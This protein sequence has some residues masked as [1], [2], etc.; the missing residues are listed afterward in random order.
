M[1]SAHRHPA[2]VQSMLWFLSW[3][4]QNCGITH[5]NSQLITTGHKKPF[6]LFSPPP[7]N[8]HVPLQ[9]A[10]LA[11]NSPSAGWE[12]GQRHGWVWAR[13]RRGS[14]GQGEPHL[15]LAVATSI[16]WNL[17]SKVWTSGCPEGSEGKGHPPG[18]RKG[19]TPQEHMWRFTSRFAALRKGK[20]WGM[21]PWLGPLFMLPWSDAQW[22]RNLLKATCNI[23]DFLCS[24]FGPKMVSFF[25][26]LHIPAAFANGGNYASLLKHSCENFVGSDLVFTFVLRLDFLS[27]CIIINVFIKSISHGVK[28]L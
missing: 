19:M 18:T 28:K 25:K 15:S 16:S 17:M 2:W 9:G 22:L 24:L 12:L 3:V 27:V 14:W 13:V 11:E 4:W 26:M 5:I 21:E 23:K 6:P 20:F 10:K 1:P 7:T 8:A